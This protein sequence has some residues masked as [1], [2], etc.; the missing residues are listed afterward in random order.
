MIT[1]N[2]T[3]DWFV[4]MIIKIK[5]TDMGKEKYTISLLGFSVQQLFK[6]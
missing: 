3:N 5:S 1:G 6:T 4:S 2:I